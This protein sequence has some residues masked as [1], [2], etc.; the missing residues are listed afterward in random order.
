MM[1]GKK[2]FISVNI[3][4]RREHVQKQLILCNFCEA[5]ALFKQGYETLKVRFSKFCELRPK[6]CVLAGANGKHSVCVC[7][8]HQNTKRMIMQC[9]MTVI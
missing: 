1:P 4:G 3:N 5:F 2:D 6:H 9:R 8:T 7:T